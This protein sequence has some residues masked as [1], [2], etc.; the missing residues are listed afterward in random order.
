MGPATYY[1]VTAHWF[2][3]TTHN[4]NK[5][6][7]VDTMNRVWYTTPSDELA[8]AYLNHTVA[9]VSNALVSELDSIIDAINKRSEGETV[10]AWVREHTTF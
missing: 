4:V 10:D 9:S 3:K 6:M 2:A 5:N 8:N 1:T 7:V